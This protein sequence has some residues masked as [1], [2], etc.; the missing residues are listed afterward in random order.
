MK[1]YTVQLC[2]LL[3]FMCSCNESKRYNIS[4]IS[5]NAEV[6]GKDYSHNKSQTKD[7]YDNNT[8]ELEG[9][10]DSFYK[11]NANILILESVKCINI[12]CVLDNDEQNIKLFNALNKGEK[13]KVFGKCQI[14]ENGI[15]IV[16]SYLR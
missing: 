9:Y 10:V 11:N 12:T 16:E 8:I 5:V 7:T 2:L 4:K 14:L 3:M 1:N 13:V 6:I 15:F